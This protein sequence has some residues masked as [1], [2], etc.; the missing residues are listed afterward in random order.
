MFP[1]SLARV[2]ICAFA[3]S[4]LACVSAQPDNTLNGHLPPPVVGGIVQDDFGRV[5]RTDGK[6]EVPCPAQDARTAVLLLIGQSN[7]ANYATRP[8]RSRYGNAVINYFAGRCYVAGSP[9]LGAGGPW[10]EY[11]TELGNELVASRAY[12]RVVLIAAAIGGTSIDDWRAP[13]Q[14]TA[15]G[16]LNAMLMSV[17]S[18]VQTHFEITHVLWH[19]G[20]RD[21][22]M[23]MERYRSGFLSLTDSLRAH[24]VTAPIFVSVTSARRGE[25]PPVVQA[26]RGLPDPTVGIY[27]GIDTDDLILPHERNVTGHFGPEAERKV[28]RAWLRTLND[29]DR[30]VR[31][32]RSTNPLQPAPLPQ[33]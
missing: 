3:L 33:P 16:R 28:V 14:G 31:R 26:Q 13:E 32:A 7:A 1:R 6:V 11:W 12:R 2:L 24:G 17:L 10:A 29:Y 20:E 22:D 8:Y 25:N 21:T 19:Q 15:D 4:T 30:V 23:P 9:L 27:P 18:D 5:V